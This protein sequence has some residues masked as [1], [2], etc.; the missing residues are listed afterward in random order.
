MFIHPLEPLEEGGKRFRLEVRQGEY[1]LPGF[2]SF[3]V[4]I[5]PEYAFTLAKRVSLLK[6]VEAKDPDAYELYFWDGS[7]DYFDPSPEDLDGSEE[8]CRTECNQLVVRTGAVCWMAYP[9]HGD[10]QLT[11]EEIPLKEILSI[12]GT[13]TVGPRSR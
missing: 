1:G 5:R 11:T 2:G 8:P 4:D 6:S 13:L 9:K 7:G 12:A 3:V 10:V